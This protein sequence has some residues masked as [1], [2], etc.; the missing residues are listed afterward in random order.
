MILRGNVTSDYLGMDTGLTVITPERPSD[1]PPQCVYLLHGLHGNNGSWADLTMLPAHAR[2]YNL[3]IVMPEVAR[4]FYTDMEY[5]QK[6]FS[7]VA[8]ELPDICERTF[9]VAPGRENTAVMGGSMGGNGALKCALRRPE[10]FGKC[11]AISSG[12]LFLRRYIED[13][14]RTGNLKK[15]EEQLGPQLVADFRAIL[16]GDFSVKPEDDIPALAEQAAKQPE[17]AVFYSICGLDDEPYR[18]E[19]AAFAQLMQSLGFAFTHQEIPGDHHW[20]FFDAALARA[21]EFFFG[22]GT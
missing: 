16:G 4:S 3:T 6:F 20:P 15:A 19:N 9:A 18:S 2:K 12:A 11:A 5:G 8:D 14:R 10:R 13:L 17:Q 1:I 7:Y 22:S 21:L